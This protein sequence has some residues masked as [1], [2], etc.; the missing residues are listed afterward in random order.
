MEKIKATTLGV[1]SVVKDSLKLKAV[2]NG[3]SLVDLTNAV[4]RKAIDNTELM[5]DS[6]KEAKN[7]LGQHKN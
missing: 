7:G 5:Q 3:V 4:L 2:T 1:D 6:I